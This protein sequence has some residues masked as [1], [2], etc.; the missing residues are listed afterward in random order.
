VGHRALMLRMWLAPSRILGSHNSPDFD[1]W[2]LR[3]SS[4]YR[5]E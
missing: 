1:E 5:D 2:Q 4:K 3:N